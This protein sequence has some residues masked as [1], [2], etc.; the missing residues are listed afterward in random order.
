MNE[1]LIRSCQMQVTMWRS[2]VEQGEITNPLL[3]NAEYKAALLSLGGVWKK[4]LKA[5][6][7]IITRKN[8]S[9]YI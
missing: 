5:M 6:S 9:F 2:L 3:N 1:D 7:K 8:N 4:N